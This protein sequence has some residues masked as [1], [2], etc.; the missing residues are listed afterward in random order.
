MLD[1]RAAQGVRHDYFRR[2]L[3]A[4]ETTDDPGRATLAAGVVVRRGR[5]PF[6]PVPE[7]DAP[8][9]GRTSYRDPTGDRAVA[10]VMR[11]GDR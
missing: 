7:H 10:R 11:A 4:P 6:E 2:P 8:L 3:Q 5:N 1:P 9:T